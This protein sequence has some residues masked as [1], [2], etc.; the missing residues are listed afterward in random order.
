MPPGVGRTPTTTDAKSTLAQNKGQAGTH[1]LP[2]DQ[3]SPVS[4][5]TMTG[6]KKGKQTQERTRS[7][8]NLN[9][10]RLLS[11]PGILTDGST[12]ATIRVATTHGKSGHRIL[13]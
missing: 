11:L 12:V 5:T 3:E 6:D 9:S 8:N 10:E 13:P 7:P 4:P 1:N 2:E